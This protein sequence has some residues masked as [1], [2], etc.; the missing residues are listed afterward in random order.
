MKETVVLRGINLLLQGGRTQNMGL[1]KAEKVQARVLLEMGM[2]TAKEPAG[3]HLFCL[4]RTY[5]DDS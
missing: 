2:R 4:V 5:R 3:G 1:H